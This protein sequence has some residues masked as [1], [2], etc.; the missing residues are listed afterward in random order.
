MSNFN[1]FKTHNMKLNSVTLTIKV[2]KDD[3]LQ[4]IYAAS[5]WHCVS[6]KSARRVTADNERLCLMKMKEGY[7]D[8]HSRVMGY[9]VFANFNPNLD[10]A[11]VA[12]TFKFHCEPS[13]TMPEELKQIVTQY[14]ANFVLM[15]LYG[16]HVSYYSIACRKYRAQMLLVFARDANREPLR[17]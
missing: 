1:P 16:E 12:F 10:R 13:V 8:L 5:S 14:L 2:D 15:R 7:D 3:I 6:D 11:N 17:A 4:L 9:T